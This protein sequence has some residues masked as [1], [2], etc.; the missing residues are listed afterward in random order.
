MGGIEAQ[1]P[2]EQHGGN[3]GGAHGQAGVAG[4]RLLDRI[5]GQGAD[6]VCHALQLVGV[7]VLGRV[8]AADS[9]RR[10][11]RRH[12][13]IAQIGRGH[14]YHLSKGS[15]WSSAVM[16]RA[17]AA[18]SGRPPAAVAQGRRDG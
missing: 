8:H 3:V 16:N 18:G 17:T 14:K 7:A 6:R 5:H 10:F 1:E 4:I 2:G 9:L 11:Y 12:D 15:Q 13:V